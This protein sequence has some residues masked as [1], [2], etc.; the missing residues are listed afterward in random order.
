MTSF[1]GPGHL[2]DGLPRT[3]DLQASLQAL[4][5]TRPAG[6]SDDPPHVRGGV[7]LLRADQLASQQRDVLHAGARVVFAG[8]HG[9]LVE[10]L[11]RIHRPATFALVPLRPAAIRRSIPAAPVAA[12]ALLPTVLEFF[13]GHGGFSDDGRE[14]VIVTRPGEP[15]PQPWINVIANEQFGCLVSEAGAGCAWAHNSQSNR[16]TPWSND[17]VSD[18]PAEVLFIR[19][20]ESGDLWS[21]TPRPISGPDAV[22]SPATVGKHPFRAHQQR[23]RHRLL[24]FVARRIRVRS[25]ACGCAPVERQRSVGDC[26][27]RVGARGRPGLRPPRQS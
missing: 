21:A 22:L 26:L 23:H 7:F 4:I 16:L 20:E 19:D 5:R 9:S 24:Q 15:T 12:P 18:P 27:R 13:N 17:P 8:R 10:Q 1:G 25:R 14:Y 3:Q 2:K 11:G 6:R